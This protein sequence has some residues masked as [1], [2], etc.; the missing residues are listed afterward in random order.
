[1]ECV[2]QCYQ[3]L[4][5][6]NSGYPH[7]T[8]IV[9]MMWLMKQSHMDKQWRISQTHLHTV[10]KVLK[11]MDLVDRQKIHTFKSSFKKINSMS[12]MNFW[13]GLEI[14]LQQSPKYK[15]IQDVQNE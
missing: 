11:F 13:N 3:K 15:S 9:W 1:M 5:Y 2:K 14:Q 6:R 10:F 8:Q 4:I 12:G 7:T